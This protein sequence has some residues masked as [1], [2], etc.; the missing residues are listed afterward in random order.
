MHSKFLILLFV[1]LVKEQENQIETGEKGLWKVD[2]FLWRL[3]W[4]VS[5]IKRVSCSKDR[6]PSIKTGCDTCLGN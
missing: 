3:S 2:I 4:V 5:T 1:G 6:C